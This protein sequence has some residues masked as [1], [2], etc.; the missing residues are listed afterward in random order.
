VFLGYSPLHKGVKCLDISTGRIYISRDVVFD[1]NVFPFHALHPN[2]GALL[3]KEI[4]LLPLNY[5]VEDAHD[6]NEHMTSIVPIVA[7]NASLQEP[8]LI[9]DNIVQ[10]DPQFSP[11]NTP[12]DDESSADSEQD[13][14]EHSSDYTDPKADSPA[15]S[16]IS[17]PGARAPLL[18]PAHTGTPSSSPQRTRGGPG[19]AAPNSESGAPDPASESSAAPSSAG[20]GVSLPPPSPPG[21]RT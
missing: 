10:N 6:I 13:F 8:A 3:K 4:L 18:S 17:S 2:A 5:S 21:P 15:P 7:P 1:E 14:E 9:I 20:A 11:E 12:K 16:S 19:P